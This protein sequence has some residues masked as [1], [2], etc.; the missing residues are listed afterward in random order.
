MQFVVL[1]YPNKPELSR[2]LVFLV[3]ISVSS[4]IN[5]SQDG[6]HLRVLQLPGSSHKEQVY[7]FHCCLPPSSSQP[8][9]MD[10]CGGTQLM[11]AALSG[12]HVTIFAYGQTG[13]G[14]TFTMFGREDE[15]SSDGYT[16]D[17]HDGL[18]TR[19]MRYIYDSIG[20]ST[21]QRVSV[22]ASYL[23]VYNECVY[24][25]LN[26]SEK[27]L[28]VKWD[29][30]RGFWVPDLRSVECPTFTKMAYVI[31]TGMK[32]R[33][34]GAHVLNHES[35]RSHA[36]LVAHVETVDTDVDSIN[37]GQARFGK[38]TFVDLAGSERVKETRAHGDV[39]KEANSINKSL[40]MLGKVIATLSATV[41]C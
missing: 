33:R 41:R 4:V 23:E 15:L 10:A 38:I 9:F 31:H 6:T 3:F 35:S 29:A 19:C 17:R 24:D 2:K 34:T 20:A 40:F 30:N 39:M 22:K 16:G 14:K 37:Y 7:N 28:P 12:Y 18:T 27:Q 8:D 32:H 21:G 5:V 26:L 25:L 36:L 11:D 13:S 1:R